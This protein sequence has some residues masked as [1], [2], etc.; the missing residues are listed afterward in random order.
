MYTG[1]LYLCITMLLLNLLSH[2][3]QLY[4]LTKC[5]WTHKTAATL[6]TELETNY[7]FCMRVS[8]LFLVSTIFEWPPTIFSMIIVVKLRLKVNFCV[9]KLHPGLFTIVQVSVND[10]AT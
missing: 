4:L 10:P 3:L 9:V 1:L 8:V 5:S 7:N 6:H 2:L